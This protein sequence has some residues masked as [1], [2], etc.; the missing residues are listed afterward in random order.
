MRWI[1]IHVFSLLLFHSHSTHSTPIDFDKGTV[2]N[3]HHGQGMRKFLGIDDEKTGNTMPWLKES[4]KEST[5]LSNFHQLRGMSNGDNMMNSHDTSEVSKEKIIANAVVRVYEAMTNEDEN[6]RFDVI[7]DD[8]DILDLSSLKYDCPAECL[9]CEASSSEILC[10]I[11]CPD[12]FNKPLSFA[13]LSTQSEYSD[14]FYN[15]LVDRA[16]MAGL[17]P[18]SCSLV[19]SEG[20]LGRDMARVELNAMIRRFQWLKNSQLTSTLIPPVQN[21]SVKPSEVCGYYE[22]GKM[23]GGRIMGGTEV[24]GTRKYPWQMS[25]ATSSSTMFYHHLCGAALIADRW[26]VTA[27]HCLHSFSRRRR[28]RRRLYVMGG[29]LALS[30]RDT[31]QIYEVEEFIIHERFVPRLYEQD[32]ALIRLKSS[33]VYTP[34]LLPVCLP[35]PTHGRKAAYSRHLGRNATLTGW[36]RRWNH[37]PLATQLEMVELPVISNSMC[38]DW[39]LKS[40]SRQVIPESTFVCAGWEEGQ[41]DAC[42]GDSGGPLVLSRDDGRAEMVG[43]VSWGI[44]CGVRGRPGVYTRVSEFVP[45]IWEKIRKYEKDLFIQDN[46]RK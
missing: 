8:D 29:F 10:R 34:S 11:C 2:E 28:G 4:N 9:A 41:M 12:L 15:N 37:G 38:M 39:Y 22:D 30:E 5:V 40:G 1:H 43:I 16:T 26:V 20:R 33:V 14:I 19:Q 36:G 7:F 45:W 44:G 3:E 6:F 42:S 35:E 23:P 17:T 46:G 32:I 25:L 31:A 27:A 13:K 21:N 18:V 24:L